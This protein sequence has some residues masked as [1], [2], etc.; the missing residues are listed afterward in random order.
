MF[1]KNIRKF[2]KKNVKRRTYFTPC[3]GYCCIWE[4]QKVKIYRVIFIC[5]LKTGLPG[6]YWGQVF[7]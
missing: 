3:V 7:H 4:D 6:R 5:K 2:K 1:S